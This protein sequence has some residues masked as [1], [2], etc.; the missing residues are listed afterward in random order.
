MSCETS[1]ATTDP[2]ILYSDTFKLKASDYE[3]FE[4]RVR[5]QYNATKPHTLKMYFGTN[6]SG[7]LN[8]AKTLRI[9]LK[10]TDSNGEW[11]T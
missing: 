7:G 4:M 2:T 10:S 3:S 1:S 5:Y 6:V 8:E 9:A 11:E